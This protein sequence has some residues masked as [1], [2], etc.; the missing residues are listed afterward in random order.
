MSARNLGI[1]AGLVG[2]VA[3]QIFRSHA[4]RMANCFHGL[5]HGYSETGFSARYLAV[6]EE[7][8]NLALYLYPMYEP[9]SK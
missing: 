7:A 5:Q 9:M 8:L 1:L 3:V 4:F 2:A 6:G